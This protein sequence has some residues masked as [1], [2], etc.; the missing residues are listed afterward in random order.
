MTVTE[1][2]G[3]KYSVWL[4][5]IGQGVRCY[6]TENQKYLPEKQVSPVLI[7]H[8]SKCAFHTKIL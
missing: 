5:G 1:C 4:I 6:K 2:K 3:C 8:I 7:G